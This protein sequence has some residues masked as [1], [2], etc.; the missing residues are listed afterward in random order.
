MK[1]IEIPLD[2]K[3]R[4]GSFTDFNGVYMYFHR[5]YTKDLRQYQSPGWIITINQFNNPED[6]KKVT[7]VEYIIEEKITQ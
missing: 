7:N 4:E 3:T 2:N 5:F 1:E 6:A